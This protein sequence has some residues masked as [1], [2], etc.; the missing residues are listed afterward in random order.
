MLP[1]V[2]EGTE[3]AY[4]WHHIT[5]SIVIAIPISLHR[6]YHFPQNTQKHREL[7]NERIETL[8][9]INLKELI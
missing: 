5:D 6:H 4:C 2:Y 7:L 9:G 1:N 3:I 8:Y